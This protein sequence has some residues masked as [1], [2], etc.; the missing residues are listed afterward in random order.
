MLRRRFLFSFVNT[1]FLKML[2]ANK[3]ILIKKT[4]GL[5]SSE[6]KQLK[7]DNKM[8]INSDI[9]LVSSQAEELG[10]NKKFQ[11][12]PQV[13]LSKADAENIRAIK[14][15]NITIKA[16]LRA[17]T[18]AAVYNI[19]YIGMKVSSILITA[20]G[21]LGKIKTKIN[22]SVKANLSFA[23][24]KDIQAQQKIATASEISVIEAKAEDLVLDDSQN[25]KSNAFMATWIE[26]VLEN[27]VLYIRQVYDANLND[28]VLEVI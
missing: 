10:V 16:F 26:P 6:G 20:A 13:K 21:Y 3:N 17:Y 15:E 23:T 14:K 25:I 28:G 9:D 24:A 12:L 5:K 4:A 27:G 1:Y 19:S 22:T 7:A 8:L 18:R 11:I 2:F